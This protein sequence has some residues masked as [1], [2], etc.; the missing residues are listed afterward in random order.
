LDSN[1]SLARFA[2]IKS[3]CLELCSKAFLSFL[4]IIPM[5]GLLAVTVNRTNLIEGQRVRLKDFL[6]ERLKNGKLPRGTLKLAAVK[7]SITHQSRLWKGWCVAHTTALNGEWDVAS[8]KK[9][10]G[11]G[12][13]Y[14]FDEVAEAVHDLPLR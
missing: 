7:F 13:K 4:V 14:N 2:K 5:V 9:A 10:Y 8:G 12:L 1:T 11:R 6:L 3:E